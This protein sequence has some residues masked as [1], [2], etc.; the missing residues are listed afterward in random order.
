MIFIAT[1]NKRW[2][3]GNYRVDIMDAKPTEMDLFHIFKSH[4]IKAN[5]F[6]CHTN[7]ILGLKSLKLCK[8]L[9]LFMILI[10]VKFLLNVK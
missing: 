10:L 9:T 1:V 4:Q 2:L 3:T 7:N 8:I 6:Y 5:Q